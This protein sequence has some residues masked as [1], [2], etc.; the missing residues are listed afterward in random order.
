MGAGV[1]GGGTALAIDKKNSSMIK[2]IVLG[3]CLFMFGLRGFA[4]EHMPNRPN[5]Y[6][7]EAP[8]K[9]FSKENLFLGGSLSVGFGSYNF[10]IGGTPEMGFALNKWLDAG[11]LVNLNY[12]S[13]RADPNLV[14][15]NNTRYR[16]FNYGAGVF[17]R[18]YP[19]PFLFLTVQPELNWIDY[20]QK[21]IPTGQ[22]YSTST[23]A[24]SLLLGIGY[25]Q[26]VIGESSFYIALMFDALN[27]TYSPYRD[28][29]GAALPILRAGFDIYL[30]KNHQY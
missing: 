2:Q 29:N 17:A 18:A 8:P 3:S 15:N 28:L 25:G 10:N 30:H 23:N 24:G 13:I 26:R 22:T 11:L 4:Q 1:K 14:Y 12:N 20:N 9:G 5:T 16:S 6:S 7:D 27:S 21:Y 19:L